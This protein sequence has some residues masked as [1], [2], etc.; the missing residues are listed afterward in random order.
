MKNEN[1]VLNI[2]KNLEKS[3]LEILDANLIYDAKSYFD[4]IENDDYSCYETLINNY[5]TKVKNVNIDYFFSDNYV[6][7]NKLLEYFEPVCKTKNEYN[8]FKL[9]DG[10]AESI[11][12]NLVTKILDNYMELPISA[13]DLIKYSFSSNIDLNDYSYLFKRIIIRLSI[14]Y[15]VYKNIN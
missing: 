2:E 5:M 9:I 1:K 12:D 7:Y 10:D 6:K 14:L 4:N 3:I 11:V 8:M 13:I 15:L